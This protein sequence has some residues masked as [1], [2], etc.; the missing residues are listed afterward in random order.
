MLAEDSDGDEEE[1][2]DSLSSLTPGAYSGSEPQRGSDPAA[3]A[4]SFKRRKLNQLPATIN[5]ASAETVKTH[6]DGFTDNHSNWNWK[7]TRKAQFKKEMIDAISSKHTTEPKFD[8]HV[9]KTFEDFFAPLPSFP[10]ECVV[11]WT[12]GDA[13]RQPEYAICLTRQLSKASLPFLAGKENIGVATSQSTYD[14]GIVILKQEEGEWSIL[15]CTAVV[16]FKMLDTSIKI[17]RDAFTGLTFSR[18]DLKKSGPLCQAMSHLSTIVWPSLRHMR[19]NQVAM[20]ILVIAGTRQK[21]TPKNDEI[22]RYIRGDFL[23]P[24]T[25]GLGFSYQVTAAS[26]ASDNEA[27]SQA[28]YEYLRTIETGFDI[29]H[30]FCTGEMG[31]PRPLGGCGLPEEVEALGTNETLSFISSPIYSDHL[32]S[33]QGDIWSVTTTYKDIA[34]LARIK[35]CRYNRESD[36]EAKVLI[37]VSSIAVAGTWVEPRESSDALAELSANEA[38]DL[39]ALL[40]Y[41]SSA[42]G[43]I[44]IMRDLRTEGY[45]DL[46]PQDMCPE[47][48]SLSSLWLAVREL[49]INTLLPAA[50]DGYVFSDLRA[51]YDVTANVLVKHQQGSVVDLKLVDFDSFVSKN[52]IPSSVTDGRY[53]DGNYFDALQYLFLQVLLLGQAYESEIK[54]QDVGGRRLS[55]YAY[56]AFVFQERGNFPEAAVMRLWDYFWARFLEEDFSC[57]SDASIDAW[58]DNGAMRNTETLQNDETFLYFKSIL[59]VI[60]MIG[61]TESDKTFLRNSNTMQ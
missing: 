29:A 47:K 41:R 27:I 17:E 61:T 5:V 36:V 32:R 60:G 9:F 30:K 2:R 6:L 35:H 11:L 22:S 14:H 13:D 56:S 7:P 16:E 39:G 12:D 18:L 51:G 26:P 49:L 52:S 34:A 21:N 59:E 48:F 45:A 23:P 42:A 38:V 46:C 37:K 55:S 57:Q 44:T 25:C 28:F 19:T 10:P 33:S 53:L 1:G 50:K 4:E 20:P 15:Y 40:G 3:T 54:Q 31:P 58:R 8:E 24:P 43:L